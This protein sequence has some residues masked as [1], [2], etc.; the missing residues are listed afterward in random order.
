LTGAQPSRLQS[1]VGDIRKRGLLRSSA[2]VRTG[3]DSDRIKKNLSSASVAGEQGMA[4]ELLDPVAIAPGS[5][6]LRSEMFI[7]QTND[8]DSSGNK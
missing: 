4:E 3:S 7:G 1:R 2:R 8:V 5:D 6:T